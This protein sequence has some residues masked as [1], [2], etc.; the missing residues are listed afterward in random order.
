MRW[1]NK[2]E[3]KVGNRAIKNLIAY[4]LGAY[5]IGYLFYFLDLWNIV[6]GIYDMLGMNPALICRGQVWRL[7]TWVCTV[8]QSPSIFLIF[9]FM[10][11]YWIG[12]TLENVWGAFR[13]NLFIFMGL[14]LMTI[15]PMVIYLVSGLAVGF[16]Q[17]LN[18]SASTYYLNLTS[19]LAFATIFPDQQVYFMFILPF[20]LGN[21]TEYYDSS[22][23]S[24]LSD[25][26]HLYFCCNCFI[27]RKLP[28]LLPGDQKL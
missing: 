5:A 18:L 25:D 6:P 28:D 24:T 23:I 7:V 3:R 21:C 27:G 22:G 11:Y 13:Y 14:I 26:R 1:I 2:L 15:T 17:A 19:F 9:M 16:D 4:V 10:M 12:R 8:P 20:G